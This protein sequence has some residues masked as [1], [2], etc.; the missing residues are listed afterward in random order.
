M[1]TIVCNSYA[2]FSRMVRCCLPVV[3]YGP[4]LFT[5]L[6]RFPTLSAVSMILVLNASLYESLVVSTSDILVRVY[7]ALSLSLSF[8]FFIVNQHKNEGSKRSH[9]I[10]S[11]LMA[12]F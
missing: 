12:L 3:G 7:R 9:F 8:T 4:Q 5:Q 6:D 1:E 10:V 11:F 2:F